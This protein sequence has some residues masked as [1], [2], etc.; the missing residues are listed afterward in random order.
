MIET[1]AL[2]TLLVWADPRFATGALVTVQIPGFVSQDACMTAARV[3]R[4][5]NT[6]ALTSSPARSIGEGEKGIDIKLVSC[7][8]VETRRVSG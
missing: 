1:V 6:Q 7:L 2:W 8:P 3:L 5:N 4:E